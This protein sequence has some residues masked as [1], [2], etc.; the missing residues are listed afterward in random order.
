M[1]SYSLMKAIGDIDD[2]YVMEALNDRG[3]VKLGAT[4]KLI[5]VAVLIFLLAATALAVYHSPLLSMLFSRTEGEPTKAAEEHLVQPDATS[6]PKPQMAACDFHID[7][8]LLDGDHLYVSYSLQNPTE[9]P[10]IYEVSL[11]ANGRAL[12]GNEENPPV[13]GGTLDDVSLPATIQKQLELD[14]EETAGDTL[15]AT[16]SIYVLRPMTDVIQMDESSPVGTP[17]IVFDAWRN[18]VVDYSNGWTY[19]AS[20]NGWFS[21]ENSTG[22]GGSM[23]SNHDDLFSL[24]AQTEASD[25]IRL[26]HF[27]ALEKLGYVQIVE[28]QNIPLR[29]ENGAVQSRV[30]PDLCLD[31]GIGELEIHSLTVGAV[32]TRLTAVLRPYEAWKSFM[33]DDEHIVEAWVYLSGES[34]PVTEGRGN[35]LV[36]WDFDFDTADPDAYRFELEWIS[37]DTPIQ[38]IRIEFVDYYEAPGKHLGS[39]E[40]NVE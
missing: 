29:F 11:R 13:L 12:G 27:Q 26:S 8:Y 23:A 1:N 7:E 3:K 9:E 33:N 39:V 35:A 15:D 10:L 25:D 21:D 32:Q 37:Q 18:R 14:L 24:K 28:R 20:D 2:K 36:D 5:L 19:T 22:S 40:W 17:V 34:E 31:A 38:D 30:D 16:L 4:R 6:Q